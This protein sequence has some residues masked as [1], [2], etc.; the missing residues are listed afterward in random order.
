MEILVKR[1]HEAAVLP[2]YEREAGSGIDLYAVQEVVVPPG[3][4][5]LIST[6][7]AVAFPI[8]Y[9]G[10]IVNQYGF[11]DTEMIQIR[12]GTI[13]S[14]YRQEVCVEVTNAGQYPYTFTQG[15]KVAQMIIQKVE[16]VS[17]IEA[18]DLSTK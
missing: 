14:G 10:L 1:V 7:I 9:I 8:G 3:G 13:D 4:R 18:E 5:A 16:R 17:L 2:A 6:G 11:L 12:E 15:A